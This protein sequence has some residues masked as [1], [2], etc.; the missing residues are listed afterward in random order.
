MSESELTKRKQFAYV[1][2]AN[3]P[4]KTCQDCKLFLPA[5]PNES[6]GVCAL[7]KGPVESLGSCTYWAP[8]EV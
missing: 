6:C 4:L 1:T 2:V 8:L 5:M 7:F 3:E